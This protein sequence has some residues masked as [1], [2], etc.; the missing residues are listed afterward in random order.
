MR[1]VEG[2][3]R[4]EGLELTEFSLVDVT[5][6]AVVLFERCGVKV[7][8]V[9]VAVDCVLG[10]LEARGAALDAKNDY[11]SFVFG[12]AAKARP[13]CCWI[14]TATLPRGSGAAFTDAAAMREL[15]G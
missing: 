7:A 14:V 3:A 10:R 11:T 9:V 2:G 8:H 5:L 6:G 12:G 4:V 1:R 13:G 15:M